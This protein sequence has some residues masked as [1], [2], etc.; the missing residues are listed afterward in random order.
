[1]TT[2]FIPAGASSSI[3]KATQ[4]DLEGETGGDVYGTPALLKY[5]P[6]IVKCWGLVEFA[7]SSPALNASY[8]TTSV[9]RNAEGNFT[10]TIE[11]DFSTANY[12][13]LLTHM[14]ASV[15]ETAVGSAQAAGTF[16]IKVGDAADAAQDKD[17]SYAMLGDQ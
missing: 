3:G 13:V 10:A 1:M 5:H 16:V 12:C 15:G 14:N 8:N 17:F 6:G 2:R 7:N 4:A 11:T 9:T